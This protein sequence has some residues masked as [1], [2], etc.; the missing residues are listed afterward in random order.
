MLP[1]ANFMVVTYIATWLGACL[2]VMGR[3]DLNT[4]FKGMTPVK[5]LLNNTCCC[6]HTAS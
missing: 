2:K 6:T 3:C 1:D 5:F 4:K